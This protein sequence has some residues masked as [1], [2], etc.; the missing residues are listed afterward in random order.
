VKYSGRGSGFSP[1]SLLDRLS[2]LERREEGMPTIYSVVVGLSSSLCV[3]VQVEWGVGWRVVRSPRT[4]S[5]A[6][7]DELDV[8]AVTIQ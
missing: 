7:P 3:F 1:L 8:V 4:A 2:I 6:L 5:R